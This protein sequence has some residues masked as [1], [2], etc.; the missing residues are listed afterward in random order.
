MSCAG[1]DGT[2][3]RPVEKAGLCAAHRYRR[4]HGSAKPLAASVREQVRSP[5]EGMERAALEYKDE[6]E[7]STDEEHQRVR[8]RFRYA[9]RQYLWQ[10][11]PRLLKRHRWSPH[12]LAE[13]EAFLARYGDKSAHGRPPR[14]LLKRR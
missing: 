4:T 10:Y 12:A 14:T 9:L 5:I 13:I 6:L 11:V 3:E 7:T 1:A 8:E 2:C